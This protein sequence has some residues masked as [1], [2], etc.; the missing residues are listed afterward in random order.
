MIYALDEN[1][2]R[3]EASES[4]ARAVCP[5]C[6]AAVVAKVGDMVMRHWAHLPDQEMA[7]QCW[8]EPETEWHRMLKERWPSEWREA[9]VKRDGQGHR[10][11]VLKPGKDGGL[12][13]EF[14]RST[15]TAEDVG[16]RVNF[17]HRMVWVFHVRDAYV[18]ERLSFIRSEDAFGEWTAFEWQSPKRIIRRIQGAMYWDFG[19]DKWLRPEPRTFE[20]LESGDGKSWTL[21]GGGWLCDVNEVL[22]TH[23]G[24]PFSDDEMERFLNLDLPYGHNVFFQHGQRLV[25]LNV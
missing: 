24:K 13:F 18:G 25:E 20:S 2:L 23:D 22:S 10:A 7:K 19:R 6:G 5:E 16:K 4:G 3:V 14:Q 17:Y 11:D 21:R 9:I 15:I 8:H 12:A 1:Q